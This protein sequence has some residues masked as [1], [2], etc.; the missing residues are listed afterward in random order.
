MNYK[1]LLAV[2]AMFTAT[3]L[4]GCGRQSADSGG[5]GAT[6]ADA[7]DGMRGRASLALPKASVLRARAE[8]TDIALRDE[9]IADGGIWVSARKLKPEF[10]K[11]GAFHLSKD[12]VVRLMAESF[13]E[14][15]GE[16]LPDVD[17]RKAS[18]NNSANVAD[19][20]SARDSLASALAFNPRNQADQTRLLNM[21]RAAVQQLTPGGVYQPVEAGS[22][23]IAVY[24]ETSEDM[25]D[26]SFHVF[27]NVHDGTIVQFLTIEGR[28]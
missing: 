4:S 1:K 5:G 8:S 15:R 26:V 20:E 25:R 12:L 7:N 19:I 17:S 18:V 24:R 6:M 10:K 11:S 16:N 28:M 14:M 22:V 2:V 3:G 21:A 13:K 9:M 27:L 23:K